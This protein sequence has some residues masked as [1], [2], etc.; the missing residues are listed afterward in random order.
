MSYLDH[1]KTCSYCSNNNPQKPKVRIKAASSYNKQK[2]L[3]ELGAVIRGVSYPSLEP[4]STFKTKGAS[5]NYSKVNGPLQRKF[6]L[7][8][9]SKMI[10]GR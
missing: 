7:R 3:S 9:L 1:L 8:E 4:I 10:R 5:V 2:K 6:K